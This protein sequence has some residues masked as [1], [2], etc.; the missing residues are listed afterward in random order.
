[1]NVRPNSNGN[2]SGGQS[3]KDMIQ[4]GSVTAKDVI[5]ATYK[6]ITNQKTH[7]KKGMYRSYIYEIEV[8]RSQFPEAIYQDKSNPYYYFRVD[9]YEKHDRI[10]IGGED[11]KDIF[12]ESLKNKSLKSLEEFFKKI[13]PSRNYKIITKWSG[14]VLEPSDGLALIGQ[15]KPAY[16][17][18]TAFSGN[19]MTYSMISAL[20]IRDLILGR[21]NK[22]AEVYDPKRSILKPKRLGIKAK[23]YIE[24]FFGGALKN[25]LK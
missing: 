23:D 18:A 5:I 19:G 6:P 25:M 22:W 21:M 4:H 2:S 9:R 7:L 8:G 3:A 24:E 15:I 12:G 14:K 10:I 16:Y 20:I 1:V 17:V 11:H 13:Y